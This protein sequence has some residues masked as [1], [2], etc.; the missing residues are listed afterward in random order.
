MCCLWLSD[1]DCLGYGDR[2]LS[3]L[4]SFFDVCGVCLDLPV[5]GMFGLLGF[6]L[7]G[8]VRVLLWMDAWMHASLFGVVMILGF[9]SAHG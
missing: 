6:A 7:G 9:L 1:L 3:C 2:H 8:V 5:Y 4:S